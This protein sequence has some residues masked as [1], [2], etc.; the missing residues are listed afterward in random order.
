MPQSYPVLLGWWQGEN[1]MQRHLWPGIS[2][3]RDT[4]AKNV[5]EIMSQ[6]MISR[7]MLPQSKGVV[8]WNIFSVSKNPPMAKALIEGPYK[9]QA[10]VPESPWLGNQ[11]PAAP[12]VTVETQADKVTVSWTHPD[13]ATVFRWVVYYQYGNQKRYQI[14]NRKDRSVVLER[15]ATG[16]GNEKLTVSNITVSAVDRLGNESTH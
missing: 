14:L 1:T 12:T 7:G 4:S 8:H 11:A 6:I 16:S 13:E 9:K 3:G 5:N 2:V 10:L 15:L